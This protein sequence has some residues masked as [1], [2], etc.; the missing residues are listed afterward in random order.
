VSRDKPRTVVRLE[1]YTQETH[2]RV[3]HNG[4][5][6]AGRTTEASGEMLVSVGLAEVSVVA[7]PA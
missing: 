1:S 5:H 4:K 2:R 3:T 6:R 7:V